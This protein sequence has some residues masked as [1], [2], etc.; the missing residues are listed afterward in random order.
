[1]K[2]ARASQADLEAASD[3]TRIVD[4][5]EKGY[6]PSS[7]ETEDLEFFDRDDPEQ[8]QRALGLILDVAAK[9]SLFRVTFGMCVVLDPRNELLDPDA[10]T[11]EKHPKIVEALKVR[12]A[13]A[14]ESR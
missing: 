12:D 8:C 9:G 4:E 11:I 14:G 7:D 6:M 10:D 5:L 2:M 3:V 1:M 13:H